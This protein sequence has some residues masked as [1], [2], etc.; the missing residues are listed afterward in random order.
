MSFPSPITVNSNYKVF[1][2]IFRVV[3][4]LRND[5]RDKDIFFEKQVH[6]VLRSPRI[7]ASIM[8]GAVRSDRQVIKEITNIYTKYAIQR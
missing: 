2:T 8:Y 6:E 3:S 5:L 4:T 7:G 1:F